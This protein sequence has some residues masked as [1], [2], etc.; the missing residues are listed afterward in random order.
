MTSNHHNRVA[1]VNEYVMHALLD[2]EVDTQHYDTECT[3][4]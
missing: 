4:L 1:L 3:E 2:H